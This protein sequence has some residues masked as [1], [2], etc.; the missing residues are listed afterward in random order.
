MNAKSLVSVAI[1][2]GAAAATP[3]AHADEPVIQSETTTTTTT[4]SPPVGQTTTTSTDAPVDQTTTT[5][6]TTRVP[7]GGDV[8]VTETSV[9]NR[10]LLVGSGVLLLAS[11]VPSAIVGGVSDRTED[12]Y[13]FIPVV[14]PWIDYG[15]RDCNAHPCTDEDLNKAFLIGSG[16]LQG[17]GAVGVLTS[18]F[19]PERRTTLSTVS[20]TPKKQFAVAPAN[21][22]RAGY[23][24]AAVGTF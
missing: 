7:Y 5:V 14:G 1:V 13:L 24:V 16:I 15:Q 23:G 11:Y 19:V 22:G 4:T 21:V 12:R 10:P 3:S 8:P 6:S 20:S 18:F 17:V 9:P 2:I